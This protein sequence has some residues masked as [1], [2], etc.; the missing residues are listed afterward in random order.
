MGSC[1]C[2]IHVQCHCRWYH[3][4]VRVS[5]SRDLSRVQREQ[6]HHSMD[7]FTTN[8]ILFDCRY[9]L[10]TLINCLD[11]ILFIFNRSR[12]GCQLSCTKV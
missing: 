4:L 1:V 12:T 2:I 7:R 11:V 8:R 10:N 5:T 3:I 6:G 9:D